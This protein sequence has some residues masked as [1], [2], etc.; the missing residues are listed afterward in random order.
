MA[1]AVESTADQPGV[2]VDDSVSPFEVVSPLAQTQ[3]LNPDFRV[4]ERLPEDKEEIS[5][6]TFLLL[7]G[8]VWLLVTVAVFLHRVKQMFFSEETTLFTEAVQLNP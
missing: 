3:L 8:G 2:I 6:L 5:D 7:V 1:N 4:V